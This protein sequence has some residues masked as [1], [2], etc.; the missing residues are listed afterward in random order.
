MRTESWKLLYY[1]KHVT[2][3]AHKAAGVYALLKH[4]RDNKFETCVPDTLQ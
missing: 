3:P 4:V 1:R 2:F